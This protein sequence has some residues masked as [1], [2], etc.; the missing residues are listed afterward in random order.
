M[1]GVIVDSTAVHVEAWEQY[2]GEH[3]LHVPALAARMLGKHNAE[4]VREF[5]PGTLSAADILAHGARKERIYRERMAPR[6]EAS[7]VPGIRAFLHRYAGVAMGVA[8]NAEPANVEFVLDRAGIR[9]YFGAIVDGAQVRLPK[10][11]PDI[12]L[13][14][15]E[16]LGA[17]PSDCI[18]FE[19][20][21]T[22]VEAGR[23]AG[24]QVV[25]L[26]TTAGQLDGTALLI[27]DFEDPRL[28]KWLQCATAA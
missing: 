16:L 5:F 15:A 9:E 19:D 27:R 4:L 6:F 18:V 28:E 11:A 13:R 10:P 26:T 14:A 12:Y 23:A 17:R 7:L 21:A 1:D 22:G 25:G 8:T 24:M 20:S 2:L 3:S